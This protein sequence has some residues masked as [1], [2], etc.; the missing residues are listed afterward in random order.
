MFPLESM[1]MVFLKSNQS[2]GIDSSLFFGVTYILLTVSESFSSKLVEGL[3]LNHQGEYS[4][5]EMQPASPN[6]PPSSHLS[7]QMCLP[8]LDPA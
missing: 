4:Q 1:W 7:W 6:Q 3:Q 5:S 8:Q 2:H